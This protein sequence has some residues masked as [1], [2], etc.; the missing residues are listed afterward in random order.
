METAP[1]PLIVEVMAPSV[2]GGPLRADSDVPPAPRPGG[3][4]GEDAYRLWHLLDRLRERFG[5]R[6]VV[7]LIEPLSFAWIVR[8][9]R[10]RPPRY[11]AF[12]VGGRTVICSLDEATVAHT[13]ASSLPPRAPLA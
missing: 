9:V 3:P 11:P 12:V 5:S 1:R 4:G 13:I 8:V 2:G 6:I 10:H 7:H